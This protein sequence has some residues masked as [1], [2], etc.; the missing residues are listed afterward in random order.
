MVR[1]ISTPS[2]ISSSIAGVIAYFL[3]KPRTSGASGGSGADG[4]VERL[5]PD[6]QLTRL[7]ARG[8]LG[9]VGDVIDQPAEGIEDGDVA[10][11]R[12]A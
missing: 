5:P 9:R 7:L 12:L 11:A 6:G 4:A 2:M 8:Q 10:P 3:I 1:S